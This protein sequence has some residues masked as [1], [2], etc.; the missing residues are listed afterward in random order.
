[1]HGAPEKPRSQTIEHGPAHLR[2]GGI[3]TEYDQAAA[4][5][6]VE[7]SHWPTGYCPQ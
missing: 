4:I 7:S 5:T 3:P 1:M 2:Y 6:I